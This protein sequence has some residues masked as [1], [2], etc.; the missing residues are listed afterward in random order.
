MGGKTLK[1]GTKFNQESRTSLK[2]HSFAEN[3]LTGD[4][5]RVAN[6]LKHVTNWLSHYA[7]NNGLRLIIASGFYRDLE[8][9]E[10]T[11][12]I[13]AMR[14]KNFVGMRMGSRILRT[15]FRRNRNCKRPLMITWRQMAVLRSL[16]YGEKDPPRRP[17]PRIRKP[18]KVRNYQDM[19]LATKERFRRHREDEA[20]QREDLKRFR[21]NHDEEYIV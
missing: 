11:K 4:E 8:P 15:L 1:Y 14:E 3:R 13:A 5:S 19:A 9:T 18:T 2:R 7:V 6:S 17:G 21:S 10:L 16:A 12:L 20:R